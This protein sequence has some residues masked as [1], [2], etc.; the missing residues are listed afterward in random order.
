MKRALQRRKSMLSKHSS[1]TSLP[2]Y[3]ESREQEENT[4]GADAL[5]MPPSNMSVFSKI[6]PETCDRQGTV[7]KAGS[8]GH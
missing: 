2:G 1:S 8:K 4:K 6:H 7:Q 5:S 3:K